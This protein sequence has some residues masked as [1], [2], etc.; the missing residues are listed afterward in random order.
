MKHPKFFLVLGAFV[1]VLF[2]CSCFILPDVSEAASA[3]QAASDYGQTL[4]DTGF[5]HSLDVRISGPERSMSLPRN[6]PR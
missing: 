5:V 1:I 6:R 2:V 3:G 4:F